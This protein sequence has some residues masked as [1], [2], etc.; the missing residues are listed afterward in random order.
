L[1]CL[2]QQLNWCSYSVCCWD[3]LYLFQFLLECGSD[4]VTWTFLRKGWSWFCGYKIHPKV[5]KFLLNSW[6]LF[7]ILKI[8]L[9]FHKKS[10]KSG[11]ETWRR[12]E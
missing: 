11:H 5:P 12:N 1:K 9:S 4:D 7:I 10:N 6:C 3:I 8:N 2:R